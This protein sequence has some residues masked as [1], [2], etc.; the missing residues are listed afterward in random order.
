MEIKVT[1][2]DGN[3]ATF[4]TK[5]GTGFGFLDHAATL[6]TKL[7][8]EFQIDDVLTWGEDI[9]MAKTP[10][11]KV[12]FIGES[13]TMVGSLESIEEDGML[14]V[15]LDA[16]TLLLLEV[17]GMPETIEIGDYISFKTDELLLFPVE[18]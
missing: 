5:V 18:Y 13:T 1:N 9:F 7:E 16:S 15:R 4:A 3:K 2:M 10:T 12:E 6:D 14:V 17:E 11:A 8:V